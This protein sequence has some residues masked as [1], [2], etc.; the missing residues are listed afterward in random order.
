MEKQQRACLGL[1]NADPE[2]PPQ[3]FSLLLGSAKL[4]GEPGGLCLGMTGLLLSLLECR[5][6]KIR[7]LG[8]RVKVR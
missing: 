2:S 8:S 3:R 4:P 6:G 5:L 1:I 7:S